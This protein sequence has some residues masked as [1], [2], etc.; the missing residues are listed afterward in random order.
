MS[1]APLRFSFKFSVQLGVKDGIENQV[2]KNGN[3]ENEQRILM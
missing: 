1:S 3:K 2:F